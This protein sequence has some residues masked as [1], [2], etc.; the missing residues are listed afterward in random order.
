MSNGILTVNMYEW[1]LKYIQEVK[2]EIV[3]HKVVDEW[4][5]V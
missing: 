2:Y 4:A 1:M 3:I 5:G